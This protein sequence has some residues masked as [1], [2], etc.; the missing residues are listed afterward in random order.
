MRNIPYVEALRPTEANLR[1]RDTWPVYRV[2]LETKR[3]F[4]R[5]GETL[6]ALRSTAPCALDRSGSRR[7]PC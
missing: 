2:R 1:G 7:P 4:G 5:D 6:A 3:T